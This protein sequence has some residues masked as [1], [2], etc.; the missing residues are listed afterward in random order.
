G[1]NVIR[2]TFAM[3]LSLLFIAHDLRA[4][5]SAQP[6]TLIFNAHPIGACANGRFAIALNDF[7]AWVCNGGWIQLATGPASSSS[8]AAGYIQLSGGSGTFASDSTA[9]AGFF[10]NTTTHR[11][12][13]GTTSP[14]YPVEVSMQTDNQAPQIL[15]N[16]Y[17]A[18]CTTS[19]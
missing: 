11:L 14:S 8:G 7:S 1:V 2:Y 15:I 4:Q 12:G 10:W 17:C 18:W 5:L 16:S 3:V 19:N 9:N 6:P 13:L